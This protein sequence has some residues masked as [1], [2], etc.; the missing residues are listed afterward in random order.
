[1]ENIYK[2][3]RCDLRVR[4]GDGYIHTEN[5]VNWA[6]HHRDCFEFTDS[7]CIAV[8]RSWHD[9]LSAHHYLSQH[10]VTAR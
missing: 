4:A 1:M 2:C 9:L 6:I 8:P 3:E 7:Y 5:G 10:K